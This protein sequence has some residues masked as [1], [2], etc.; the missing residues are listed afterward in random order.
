[1][2]INIKEI[3]TSDWILESEVFWCQHNG[4]FDVEKVEVNYL[5]QRG[6]H[7]TYNA[8]YATCNDCGAELEIN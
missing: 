2:N 7:N 1:M 8:P 6:N 4:G 3:E 5:D